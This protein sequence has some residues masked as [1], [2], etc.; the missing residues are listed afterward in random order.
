LRRR[1]F[2]FKNLADIL[3]A[4]GKILE[5][6]KHCHRAIEIAARDP[7]NAE[8]QRNLLVIYVRMAQQGEPA[9]GVYSC[10]NGPKANISGAFWLDTKSISGQNMIFEV[11][12]PVIASYNPTCCF[13]GG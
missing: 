3:A 8:W 1:S 10:P 7:D 4:Q 12:G 9:V 11:D 2:S 5:A 13:E 6:E